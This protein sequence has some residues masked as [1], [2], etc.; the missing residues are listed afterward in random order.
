M[1]TIAI[2]DWLAYAPFWA[3]KDELKKLGVRFEPSTRRVSG[4]S[5][6]QFKA[7]MLWNYQLA[8]LLNAV[9]DDFIVSWAFMEPVG[10]GANRII[11]RSWIKSLEDLF[12]SRIGVCR[13]GVEQS[14]FEHM[15]FIANFEQK[16]DYV[17]LRDRTNY[18]T[19]LRESRIDAVLVPQPERSRIQKEIIGTEVFEENGHLP[20]YGLYVILVHRRSEWNFDELHEIQKIVSA[21]AAELEAL[22]DDDLRANYPGLFGGLEKPMQEVRSTL[23]WMSPHEST[24]YLLGDT[25][26]SFREHL[27]RIAAYRVARFG[28]APLDFDRITGLVAAGDVAE[29]I[30]G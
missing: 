25:E 17:L 29:E 14:L 1:K 21:K 22:S 12:N 30:K 2:S 16:R 28:S 11:A 13:D 5:N 3:A 8:G 20:H 26:N 18:L 4:L 7:A 6:G 9:G 19:A 15:F 23:H 10:L 27:A 24:Q